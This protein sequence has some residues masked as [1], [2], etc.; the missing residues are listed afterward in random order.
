MDT[1]WKKNLSNISRT[2]VLEPLIEVKKNDRSTGGLEVKASYILCVCEFRVQG[3][4][5]ALKPHPL[6]S[7]TIPDITGSIHTLFFLT[8]WARNSLVFSS[9]KMLVHHF[10]S[11]GIE[12]R[13][14]W[15][16]VHKPFVILHVYLFCI[17]KW[18][19]L[20]KSFIKCDSTSVDFLLFGGSLPAP[21]PLLHS[22]PWGTK[23]HHDSNE[24]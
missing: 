2:K 23:L 12:S 6:Y 17:Y 15:S 16:G 21:L 11:T 1:Q 8:I 10:A 4:G 14:W 13:V 24:T 3:E 7:H 5:V 19:M 20:W 22:A 9:G 18:H